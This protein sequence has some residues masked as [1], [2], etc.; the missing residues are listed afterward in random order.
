MH[1]I[2]GSQDKDSETQKLP[3]ARSFPIFNLEQRHDRVRE[4][5]G[6]FPNH[7][8]HAD[9]LTRHNDNL[10]KEMLSGS[11]LRSAYSHGNLHYITN[12]QKH[13]ILADGKLFVFGMDPFLG[14]RMPQNRQICHVSCDF[15]A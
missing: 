2:G 6:P 14:G 11:T 4:N 1:P 5:F 9:A 13:L 15:I 7:P 10:K 8:T 12:D 3:R